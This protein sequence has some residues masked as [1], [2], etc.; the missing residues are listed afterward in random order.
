[1]PVVKR[2]HRCKE[3]AQAVGGNTEEGNYKKST[4]SPTSGYARARK[5]Y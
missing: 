5:G 3:D 4:E 1:M 2:K